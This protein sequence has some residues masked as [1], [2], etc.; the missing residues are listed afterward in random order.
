MLIRLAALIL[1]TAAFAPRAHADTLD[2]LVDYLVSARE[3]QISGVQIK[4]ADRK[5]AA[6]AARLRRDPERAEVV[7]LA[8]TKA[9]PDKKKKSAAPLRPPRR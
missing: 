7:M 2:Q 3:A 6:N 5:P 1:L 9:A 8:V 4:P